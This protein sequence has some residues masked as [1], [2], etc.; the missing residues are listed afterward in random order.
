MKHLIKLFGI[1]FLFTACIDNTVYFEKPQPEG[2]KNLAALP[3]FYLGE[4][5]DKD[6]NQLTIDKKRVILKSYYSMSYT[7]AEIDRTKKFYIDKMYLID[8]KT[9][10]KFAFKM[11]HDTIVAQ[12]YNIDTIFNLSDDN[13]ARQFKGNLILNYKKNSSWRVEVLSLNSWILKHS[14]FTSKDLFNKLTTISNSE[15]VTDSTKKVTVRKFLKPTKK[16]F[17]NI[18]SQKDSLLINT[19]NKI[20]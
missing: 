9:N 2:L 20:K 5:L 11:A 7:K 17:E 3:T 13:I 4:Y 1:V 6:S 14:N 18:L 10:E 16:Q 15:V 8:R 19:Y 12:E